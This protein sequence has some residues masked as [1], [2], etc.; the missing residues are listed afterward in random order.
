MRLEQLSDKNAHILI[1]ETLVSMRTQ[2]ARPSISPVKARN[3]TFTSRLD[4]RTFD[5][6]DELHESFETKIST[7]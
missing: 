7:G 5:D 3:F 6:P 4:I 1:V 2:D